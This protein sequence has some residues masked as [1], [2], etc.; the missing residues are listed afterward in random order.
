MR[1]LERERKIAIIH[2]L[3]NG[4]SL[5]ATARTLNTHRTAI[6]D[7]LVRVGENCERLT[8]LPQFEKQS[9]RNRAATVRKMSSGRMRAGP[10]ACSADQVH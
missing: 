10:R 4:M 6:Q 7:L 8:Q 5:R 1:V 2:A 9:G 3:C